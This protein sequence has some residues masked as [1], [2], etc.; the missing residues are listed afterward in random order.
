MLILLSFVLSFYLSARLASDPAYLA[1]RFAPL[2]PLRSQ[3]WRAV[4]GGRI[5]GYQLVFQ[6]LR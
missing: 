5:E 6:A 1:R 2:G 3:L 4:R